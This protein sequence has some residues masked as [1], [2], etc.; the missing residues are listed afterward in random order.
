MSSCHVKN[1]GENPL[2][3]SDP[4]TGQV[5]CVMPGYICEAKTEWDDVKLALAA[6]NKAQLVSA[7]EAKKNKA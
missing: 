1:I 5:Y 7:S 3:I 4:D 6:K 2:C